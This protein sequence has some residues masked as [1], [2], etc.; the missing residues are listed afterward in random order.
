MLP[1]VLGCPQPNRSVPEDR[2]FDLRNIKYC[3]GYE[4]SIDGIVI[5]MKA[6]VGLSKR[7]EWKTIK[8]TTM[9]QGS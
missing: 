9:V 7:H 8:P 5:E 1:L 3:V 6:I 4:T 2:E